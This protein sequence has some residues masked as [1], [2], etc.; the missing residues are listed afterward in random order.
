[1]GIGYNYKVRTD[2][3]TYSRSFLSGFSISAGMK[4]KS[5]GV[6]VAF[7]QPHTGATTFMVNISTNLTELGL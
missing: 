7:A 3:S 4:V 6:G 5:F 1:M 2:M